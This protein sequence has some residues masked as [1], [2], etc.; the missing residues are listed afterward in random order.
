[1]TRYEMAHLMA[2]CQGHPP[3][4]ARIENATA[5]AHRLTTAPSEWKRKA[6]DAG[7][8]LFRMV[9]FYESC[10]AELVMLSD[11]ANRARN[12]LS[13]DAQLERREVYWQRVA[14]YLEALGE[15]PGPLAVHGPEPMLT[16]PWALI[17]DD[18]RGAA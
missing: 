7:A 17:P 10:D 12:G 14:T 11:M 16:W 18:M 6:L 15:H 2:A 4:H 5:F 9:E 8:R 13:L 1:M 3:P